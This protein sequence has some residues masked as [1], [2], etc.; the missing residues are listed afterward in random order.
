PQSGEPGYNLDFGSA[1]VR[2]ISYS[3]W[4]DWMA[5]GDE[6]S[7][8]HLCSRQSS[9]METL[10]SIVFVL[11]GFLDWIRDIAWNPVVQH[12]FVTGCQDRSVRVWRILESKDDGDDSVSV[13][14]V[15]ASNIGMLGASGMRLDGVV[16]L[17]INNR[18]LLKQ[19][20]AVGDSLIFEGD[21]VDPG[22]DGTWEGAEEVGL[23]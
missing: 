4:N 22:F 7:R 21:G 20:G 8:V 18:R 11:E 14:L 9:G 17:D 23:E 6:D 19:R 12:E 1:A 2:C 15:W 3:P 16:G 10:W 13:D 5:F